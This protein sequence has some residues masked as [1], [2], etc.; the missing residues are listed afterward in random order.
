[1]KVLL[2]RDL[3][4]HTVA[5]LSPQPGDGARVQARWA[6]AAHAQLDQRSQRAQLGGQRPR[7]TVVV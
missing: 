4:P 3:C 1:V 6:R 2:C 7:E 5:V